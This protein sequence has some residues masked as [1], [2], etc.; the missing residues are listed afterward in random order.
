MFDLDCYNHFQ[1]IRRKIDIQRVELK[2][3]IDQ[4]AL[5][6]IDELKAIEDTY[7]IR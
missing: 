7:A 2:D 3:K 5:K 1:E 6:M 4:I